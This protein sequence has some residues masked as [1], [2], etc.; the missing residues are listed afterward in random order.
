MINTWPGWENSGFVGEGSFGKVY[1]IKRKEFGTDYDAALKVITIPASQSDVK[2]AYEEGMDEESVTQYFHS[3]VEDIVAE[4]AL[5]SQMKGNSNIVSYEDHMV[6]QHEDEVAWDILIRMELLT[7]LT[8]YAKK[9]PLNENDIIRLGIHMTRALEVCRKR[10]IIHRDIKPENIF[11]SK[12][13]DFKLGDFGVARVAEKTISVMSRKGTYNY[14][15]PEV[16]KGEEYSYSADIYSLGVVLYRFLND[17]R[18][19]F[20]PP[21]PTPIQY[22]DRENALNERM[23]GTELPMPAHGSDAFKEI[24]LKACAYNPKDRYASATDMREA[25]EELA[26]SKRLS[27]SAQQNETVNVKPEPVKEVVKSEPIKEGTQPESAREVVK[28]VESVAREMQQPQME[29]RYMKAAKQVEPVATN[30]WWQKKWFAP[31][32]FIGTLLLGT[33]LFNWETFYEIDDYMF[34]QSHFFDGFYAAFRYTFA[35]VFVV[36]APTLLFMGCWNGRWNP[37]QSKTKRKGVLP[38]IL[39]LFLAFVIYPYIGVVA[40]LFAIVGGI[41]ESPLATLLGIVVMVGIWVLLFKLKRSTNWK[42]PWV[43]MLLVVL[44]L[45]VEGILLTQMYDSFGSLEVGLLYVSLERFTSASDTPLAIM[46]CFLS[47]LVFGGILLTEGY[48]WSSKANWAKG[49]WTLAI[50]VT[51]IMA[52]LPVVAFLQVV[53][54]ILGL[55]VQSFVGIAMGVGALVPINKLL[56]KKLMK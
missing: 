33:L 18:V 27:A 52:F 24:V 31:C 47:V 20:L 32:L 46:T 5:M 6:V 21:Y 53:M 14:M 34:E 22:S 44:I 1:R 41:M 29:E 50:V 54:S 25:L 28:P 15:A 9:N 36:S 26:R 2:A 13:G 45:L 23:K 30:V 49:V 48:V 40:Y 16:Y 43:G 56:K 12:D 7:T 37:E 39:L 8:D 42:K 38:C 55:P 51:V 3:F 4:F 10:N 19:P 35:M 17:N 11:V